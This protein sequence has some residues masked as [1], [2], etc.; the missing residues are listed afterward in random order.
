MSDWVVK[1]TDSHLTATR[2]QTVHKWRRFSRS[3][4]VFL[5]F[6]FESGVNFWPKGSEGCLSPAGCVC[7]YVL[8]GQ[9]VFVWAAIDKACINLVKIALAGGA[10]GG[11]RWC[12]PA[13]RLTYVP[14]LKE[15][16]VTGGEWEVLLCAFF[17]LFLLLPPSLSTFYILK[18]PTGS[19]AAVL[20]I[21]RT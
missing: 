20:R 3:L 6:V 15:T 2:R 14:G 16:I 17:F 8:L 13:K 7:V 5:F 4:S 21:D 18:E 1:K 19:L 9:M 12:L 11:S 10:A